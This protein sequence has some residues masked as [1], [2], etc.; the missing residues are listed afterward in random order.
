MDPR[1]I[2]LPYA[3]QSARINCMELPLDAHSPEASSAVDAWV[4]LE[5]NKEGQ[6]EGTGERAR[7]P[8]N[9]DTC[10]EAYE[11]PYSVAGEEPF[12]RLTYVMPILCSYAL[13]GRFVRLQYSTVRSTME[14]TFKRDRM[15]AI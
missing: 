11:D 10:K 8:I 1:C 7:L 14:E 12:Y 5:P 2:R 4:L 6:T 3:S 13:G 9:G 15:R